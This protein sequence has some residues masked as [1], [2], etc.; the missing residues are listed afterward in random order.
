MERYDHLRLPVFKADIK[1]RKQK[2]GGKFEMPDG[3]SKRDFARHAQQKSG[4]LS[5]SF[6]ALKAR[7]TNIDPQLIFKIKIDQSSAVSKF[8]N[9]LAAMD[10]HILSVAENK[11]GYWVVF[12]NDHNLQEFRRKLRIYGSETGPNYDF[13]H[14][15]SSFDDIPIEE[16]IGD[17]LK[18]SPLTSTAEFVDVELWRM[19]DPKINKKFID[20]LKA[21]YSEQI[22]FRITDQL[23]TKSFVLLRVK[24]S[25]EIFDEVI[26]LKE[27][28]RIDRPPMVQFNPFEAIN[29][30]VTDIDFSA[31][32]DSATGILIIDSGIIS[33]HPMLEKCVGGTENF[34]AREDQTHDTVGHGTAVA[35]CAVYGDVGQ[36]LVNK[37]FAPSNWLF[38]A[39]VMYAE[40][41][42]VSNIINA[43]Y[44]P[45][46]LLE[47]QLKN[48]IEYFLSIAEYSI[49]VVNISLGNTD[50]VWHTHYSRQLPLAAL[51]DELAYTFSDVVFIASAG[52][53]SPL[54][55]YD[56][57]DEV[58]ESYPSYLF[59]NNKYKLINPATAALALTIGSVAPKVQV[60]QERYGAEKIK[61]A[62]AQEHQPSP[63]TRTGLGINGMIKPELVEYGG[64]VI[65]SE[66]YGRIGED[67]GGKLPLLNNRVDNNIIQL[68]SGGSFAAAK[69][70][71]LMGKIA[72]KFPDKSANFI[73]NMALVGADYPFLPD[74]GFYNKDK[75]ED[76]ESTHLAISGYGLSDFDNSVHSF[77]NRA[78]LWDEGQIAI[79]QIK[80]YSLQ[81]PELFFAEPGKKK[82]IVTLTFAPDTRSTRGDSYL[83]N[84]MK[85]HLFH[86]VSPEI[87]TEKYGIVGTDS[88]NK[89]VPEGLEKF[90]IK[91]FPGS[92]TRQAGC[93]QKAWKIYQRNP[94]NRPQ[95]P[96]SLVLLNVDKWIND[97]RHMQDYCISVVFAHEKEIDL[98]AEIRANIRTAARVRS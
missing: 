39:K 24:L 27:I 32:D 98:Y 52:N 86:S 89:G 48:A 22:S 75:R 1:R 77:N 31:P 96:I 18:K 17:Q 43:I 90:E 29:P 44:E 97:E 61:T 74:K 51:I 14:A 26:Q 50:E 57:I 94:T 80:I 11:K 15:I 59:E 95:S 72:N 16:K 66:L 53:R 30:D 41:N 49:K 54:S 23:I 65:L 83:G 87:L 25:K 67:R 79:N 85:F 35:G 73:K 38:S 4:E 63:F 81:L 7:F 91:L 60:E 92:N 70:A 68:D 71:H 93:H 45:E 10:I 13:F 12:S 55:D 20:Q 5:R 47:S 8:E 64:N 69:V 42:P 76:A 34:Q 40:K 84:A 82:I 88:N 37:R 3:R 2:G 78:V 6:S 58:A 46:T 28:A 36:S 56:S 33:N 19:L 21:N 62:I 9:E